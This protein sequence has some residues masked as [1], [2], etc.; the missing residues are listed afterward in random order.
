MLPENRVVLSQ[1]W[2][3]HAQSHRDSLN[4]TWLNRPCANGRKQQIWWS[5]KKT[6]SKIQ[7][8][9]RPSTKNYKARNYISSVWGPVQP[10]WSV[11]TLR[12]GK[13]QCF[14]PSYA[15]GLSRRPFLPV[16]EIWRLNSYSVPLYLE[17]ETSKQLKSHSALWLNPA[18]S[19]HSYFHLSQCLLPSFCGWDRKPWCLTNFS[20]ILHTSKLL[21]NPI[22][23]N[24]KIH[25]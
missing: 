1:N 9:L 19:I 22:G 17:F 10:C 12:Q 5:V 11:P 7:G 6:E 18:S 25:P 8:L 15:Q 13:D 4:R 20:F 16:R 21:A 24:F 14:N 2:R 23:S 3:T